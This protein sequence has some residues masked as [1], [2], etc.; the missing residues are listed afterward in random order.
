MEPRLRF[1]GSFSSAYVRVWILEVLVFVH[2]PSGR[3]LSCWLWCAAL[4]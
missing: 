1:V 2:K 4:L 3:Q